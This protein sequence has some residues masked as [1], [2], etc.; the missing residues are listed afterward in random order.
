VHI[1]SEDQQSISPSAF[2]PFCPFG[3][4]MSV[5]GKTINNFDIPL[6]DK[7]RP[8]FLEG[9]L[10]YQLDA[11]ELRNIVD[12]KEIASQGIVML[13][14]YNFDRMVKDIGDYLPTMEKSKLLKVGNDN[15]MDAKIYIETLGKNNFLKYQFCLTFNYPVKKD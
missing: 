3:G 14:D 10:C 15:T 6:C 2:I 9:Q 12:K 8:T 7:F 4:D 1:I 13:L 5:M 11:N